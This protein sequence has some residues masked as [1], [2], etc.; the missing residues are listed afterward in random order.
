MGE[1]AEPL[2]WRWE[3]TQ[4]A[5]VHRPGRASPPIAPCRV[6]DIG[7]G[8]DRDAAAF[9]DS[10]AYRRLTAALRV[11]ALGCIP[12]LIECVDDGLPELAQIAR[13]REA[14]DLVM[15]TAVWRR[16]DAVRQCPW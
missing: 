13:G 1:E 4:F 3:A 16:L 15:T 12:R 11:T 2:L 8:T 6:L 10:A 14:F 7:A 9:A 5:N